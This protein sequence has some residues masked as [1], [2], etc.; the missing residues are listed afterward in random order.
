MGEG[1][2]GWVA[3]GGTEPRGARGD[4]GWP[5]R[6][7]A[8]PFPASRRRGAQAGVR[9][10]QLLTASPRAVSLTFRSES[11]VRSWGSHPWAWP[12]SALQGLGR[13]GPDGLSQLASHY[14]CQS[15]ATG[16]ASL[17]HPACG[18]AP[19]AAPGWRLVK[20]HNGSPEQPGCPRC[21]RAQ[22]RPTLSPNIPTQRLRPPTADLGTRSNPRARAAC[23]PRL[24]AQEGPAGWSPVSELSLPS[25]RNARIL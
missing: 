9:P 24:P 23:G 20:G 17:G 7:P 19:R 6:A 12:I 22:S 16:K 11:D 1:G 10:D 18:V 2:T 15:G 14:L 25:P 21:P 4:T 13:W 5:P 8:L 3:R